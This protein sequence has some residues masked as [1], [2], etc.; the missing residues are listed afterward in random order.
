MS[1]ANPA[2]APAASPLGSLV[3]ENEL[4]HFLKLA[5]PEWSKPRRRGRSDIVRVLA[6]LKAAGV[7][8]IDTLIRK[9]LYN[10]GF[11]PLS[12]AALDSI[13]KQKTFMQAL[14]SV[15]VPNIRQVG[16]FDPVAQMLSRKPLPSASST[17]R[18][19]SSPSKRSDE[20][21]KALRQR[22]LPANTIGGMTAPHADDDVSPFI[23]DLL[24]PG[25]PRRLSPMQAPASANGV[26]GLSLAEGRARSFSMTDAA[27][28][29]ASLSSQQ[30]KVTWSVTSPAGQPQPQTPFCSRRPRLVLAAQL[31]LRCASGV[32]PPCPGVLASSHH[33]F[34]AISLSVAALAEF[35]PYPGCA[36]RI[37]GHVVIPSITWL[38][39]E[40][41]GS[42][43]VSWTFHSLIH[44]LLAAAHMG[45]RSRATGS[46]ARR[47]MEDGSSDD[48][49][50]ELDREAD[51]L[52]PSTEEETTGGGVH[53]DGR[54]SS[55]RDPGAKSVAKAKSRRRDL[56]HLCRSMPRRDRR[57]SRL[58]QKNIVHLGRRR[59]S[60]RRSTTSTR[61]RVLRRALPPRPKQHRG[62]DWWHPRY[63]R[64]LL[65]VPMEA[66][67]HSHIWY[68][69]RPHFYTE[70][71]SSPPREERPA[72]MSD[73]LS[74]ALQE[75]SDQD[76][77]AERVPGTP[78]PT[79]PGES[80]PGPTRRSRR[81]THPPEVDE[82]VEAE[83]RLGPQERMELFCLQTFLSFKR[84][85]GR[86]PCLV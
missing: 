34:D 33:P 44:S 74:A 2:C 77:T 39:A 13:R 35:L 29:A 51:A 55:G 80:P 65:L 72:P 30:S 26:A 6:K 28:G 49:R 10:K 59:Q 86:R 64:S 61:P 78:A 73:T 23:P 16:V 17:L 56:L 85:T 41:F 32:P 37:C 14:E 18:G 1:L 63:G 82:E 42:T 54:G 15:D 71:M 69:F 53:D 79:L 58:E 11:M 24:P 48:L 60:L 84:A 19:R 75:T 9:E 67:R 8:D 12:R 38:D 62:Q 36:I 40:L 81:A 50:S 57:P 52:L 20:G 27:L 31:P 68:R 47:G 21:R 66:A 22:C 76:A 46:R 43:G 7:N 45:K 83:N 70:P 25:K 4:V 3:A 5:R